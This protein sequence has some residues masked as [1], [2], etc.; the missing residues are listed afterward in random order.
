[1][2]VCGKDEIQSK[3]NTKDW[4]FICWNPNLQCDGVGG[5]RGLGHEGKASWMT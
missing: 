5:G 1:M 3:I 2:Q 4:M